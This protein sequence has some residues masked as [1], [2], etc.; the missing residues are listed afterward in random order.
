MSLRHVGQVWT[1][2]ACRRFSPPR[3]AAAC[4][5]PPCHSRSRIHSPGV[6]SPAR[7]TREP[8]RARQTSGG[9]SRRRGLTLF[10]L[11]IV[12]MILAI[13]VSLVIGL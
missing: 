5:R 3:L 12:M 8:G 2:A 10:E 11:L 1:A 13:L 6:A 4:M 9:G 7:T